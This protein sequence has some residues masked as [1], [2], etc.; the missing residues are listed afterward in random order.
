MRPNVL[1]DPTDLRIRQLIEHH[2]PL[3]DDVVRS[4]VGK[5]P[6]F[7]DHTE[8]QSA[9]NLG[10]VEAA[11]RFDAR[12]SVPFS[13]FAPIRIRGAI[14]D[15]LRS[16]DWAPRSVRV[17]V[18]LV[19]QAQQELATQTGGCP[20]DEAVAAEI[21]LMAS[22]LR[23]LRAN[24]MK[25]ALVSLERVTDESGSLLR[26]DQWIDRTV[27][28]ASES[29]ELDELRGYVRDAI[30]LLPERHRMVAIGCYLEGRPIAEL[31]ELMGVS[32]SRVS[33]IRSEAVEIMRD[34]IEAQYGPARSDRPYG[35][36]ATRKALF[37][38]QV[39]TSS[40]WRERLMPHTALL[41]TGD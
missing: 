21:G 2:R 38:A 25:G 16:S 6:G 39:A 14:L 9:G 8:L 30:R 7:V 37:A 1:V 32:S 36:V 3:V 29:L 35:R 27:G 20:D 34:G 15:L 10:L 26:D 28:A 4:F 18:R 12:R 40:S 17:M 23:S 11:H 24:V 13:R 22:D 41:P 19:E 31:A 33:Q 5:L